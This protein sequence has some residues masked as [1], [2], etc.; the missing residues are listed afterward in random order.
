MET[1]V[2]PKKRLP[3]HRLSALCS[4]EVLSAHRAVMLSEIP[5][6]KAVFLPRGFLLGRL[7]FCLGRGINQPT[8]QNL[9][10]QY[11]LYAGSKPSLSWMCMHGG[12]AQLQC[13]SAW[14]GPVAL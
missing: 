10:T 9:V 11:Y 4:P 8:H 6:C 7:L 2:A 1:S 13:P 14:H 3:G 12:E 5:D